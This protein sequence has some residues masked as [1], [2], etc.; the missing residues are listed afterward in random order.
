LEKVLY[1]ENKAAIR[2]IGFELLLYFLEALQSPEEPQ[3]DLLGCA[4][5]FAPF[6][7]GY[8][9]VNFKFQ[10][11]SAPEKTSILV[12]ST[13]GGQTVENSVKLLEILLDYMGTRTDTFPFWWNLFKQKFVTVFYPDISKE[14]G[15]LDDGTVFQFLPSFPLLL[16]SIPRVK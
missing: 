6:L 8:A 11:L 1:K 7:P 4:I 12:P 13:T 3:T 15:L 5:D 10:T 16:S 2:V 14:I 9:S